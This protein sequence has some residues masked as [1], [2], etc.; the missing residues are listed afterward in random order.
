LFNKSI[1]KVGETNYDERPFY[2]KFK[3]TKD[4]NTP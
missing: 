2:S 4:N 1:L 3:T